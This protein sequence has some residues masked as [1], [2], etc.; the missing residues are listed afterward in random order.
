MEA[1]EVFGNINLELTTVRSMIKALLKVHQR[2]YSSNLF[3]RFVSTQVTRKE[4]FRTILKE[5]NQVRFNRKVVKHGHIYMSF[6]GFYTKQRLVQLV[7]QLAAKQRHS[8]AAEAI[9]GVTAS[10][11]SVSP[12]RS[13]SYLT[14]MKAFA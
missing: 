5:K 1:K 13:N 12:L 14:A 10:V 7:S 9:S 4:M 2:D 11:F 6:W 3:G 8:K